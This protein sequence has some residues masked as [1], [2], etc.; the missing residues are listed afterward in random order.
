MPISK[1]FRL[2]QLTDTHL[3]S[4]RDGA[5]KGTRPFKTLQCVYADAQQRFPDTAGILL[6]GD[7]VHDEAEGYVLLAEVFNT[8]PVP[9]Y[10]L[11]GNHDLPE[12][13]QQTLKHAPFILDSH[14]V[15]HDWLLIFMNTWQHKQ[16]G[17]KL[18]SEQLRHLETL[19]NQHPQHH[20]LICMHHQPIRMSSDWLDEIGLEDAEAFRACIKPHPQV[21]GVAWGHVHQALDEVHDG[22]HYMATSSTCI[23]F[24]PR[25]ST[26]AMDS[27]P[28]GYRS[29]ELHADGSI[30]TEVL[31][32]KAQTT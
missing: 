30:T 16:V 27:Q 7:L 29:I 18:G 8:S 15:I 4:E 20:T 31:W 12:A 19:L 21:R 10:C 26:F 24:L 14:V 32:V 25:S 9:V 2:L 5:L 17:G 11:A 3:L 13:M 1:S 6:T 28:P 23:Q 22:V